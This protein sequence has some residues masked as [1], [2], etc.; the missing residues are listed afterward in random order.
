MVPYSTCVCEC[1][2]RH[3]DAWNGY[4]SVPQELPTGVA[5]FLLLRAV[6]GV[7]G[8][9]TAVITDRRCL[10]IVSCTVGLQEKILR[11]LGFQSGFEIG[12]MVLRCPA[13]FYRMDKRWR[14]FCFALIC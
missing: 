8:R 13:V 1:L 7:R 14:G 3:H 11:T 10:V 5:K 9:F 2:R 12:P 4:D 6:E